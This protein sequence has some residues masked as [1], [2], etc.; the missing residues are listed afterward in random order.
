MECWICG[1]GYVG[2]SPYEH[3][4]CDIEWRRRASRGV[5]T[6]CGERNADARVGA[7]TWCR[8]CHALGEPPYVG[9]LEAR[10]A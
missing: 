6:A 7:G 2:C 10:A 9:Y 3:E 5:C 1:G 8:E 4:S